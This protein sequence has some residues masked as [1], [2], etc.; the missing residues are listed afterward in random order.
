MELQEKLTEFLNTLESF[1]PLMNAILDEVIRKNNQ[2]T[3]EP[4]NALNEEPKHSKD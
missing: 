3:I 2:Q 1:K 4:A